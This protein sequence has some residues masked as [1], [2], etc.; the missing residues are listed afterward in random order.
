[1]SDNIH[2]Q[3]NFADGSSAFGYGVRDR[4]TIGQGHWIVL[5]PR[6]GDSD[7]IRNHERW[8]DC[9]AAE[10]VEA[11]NIPWKFTCK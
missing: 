9:R 4:N 6:G 7:D 2:H 8:E 5:W 3:L 11:N 1:M 10:W